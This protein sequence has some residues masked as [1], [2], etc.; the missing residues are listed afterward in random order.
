MIVGVNGSGKTTTV[1]KL[2]R[3]YL[4]SGQERG[5][6]RG[7]HLSRRGGRRSSGSGPSGPGS[8][9]CCRSRARTRPRSRSTPSRRRSRRACDVVLVDTAGRLHTRKDLMDEAVKIKRVCAKVKA[10]RARRG[11]AGAGRDRRPERPAPGRAFNEQLGLTGLSH[12]QAGRHGAGRR[13]D[14]DCDGTGRAHPVHR[15]GRDN[16]RTWR[17]LTRTSS[18]APCSKNSPSMSIVCAASAGVPCELSQPDSHPSFPLPRSGRRA[19]SAA[20]PVLSSTASREPRPRPGRRHVPRVRLAA[21]RPGPRH[22]AEPR[23]GQPVT[24]IAASPSIGRGADVRLGALERVLRGTGSR[25][26][27]RC[28]RARAGR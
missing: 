19:R 28:G 4:A 26:G 24:R 15:H 17:S 9:S 21:D 12:H 13:A 14:S 18:P 25:P 27:C 8:R 11:L 6:G 23:A 20:L 2:C 1:G 7:R 16:S 10:G 5:R 22:P 3:W